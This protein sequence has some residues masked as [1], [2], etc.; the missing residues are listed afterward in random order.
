MTNP[1]IPLVASLTFLTLSSFTLP[2][3]TGF[4]LKQDAHGI[5][6]THDGKPFASLVIDQANKPY[7]WPVYGPTG[8]AMTRAYPMQ[9][10]AAEPKA[11]RDHP[12]HRGLL[13]GH[14]SIGLADWSFAKKRRRPT[15][16]ERFLAVATRG[17]KK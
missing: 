10:V 1:Y 13:F 11:Q 12:H 7:L 16:R 8:K 2:A 5:E 15:S 9:D 14:E 17:M 6:I 3:A 4:A